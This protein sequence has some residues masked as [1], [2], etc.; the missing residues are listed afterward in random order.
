MVNHLDAMGRC[1]GWSV[2]LD[3]DP[4]VRVE[5]IDRLRDA[6]GIRTHAELARLRAERR[7]EAKVLVA[8]LGAAA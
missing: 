1:E 8:A 6:L 3:R 2:E 5:Q 7:A 4:D